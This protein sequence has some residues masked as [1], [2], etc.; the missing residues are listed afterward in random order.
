MGPIAQLA[1]VCAELFSSHP[2]TR[3]TIDA[4]SSDA[5]GALA[6][7]GA[8]ARVLHLKI[9]GPI[10]DAGAEALARALRS[11]TTPLL[12]LNVGANAISAS[13]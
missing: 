8:F 6:S 11:R 7:S 3:L 13:V 9:N 1:P 4:A 2:I 10:G 5:I 12:A